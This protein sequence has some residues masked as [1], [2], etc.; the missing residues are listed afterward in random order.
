MK[1]QNSD[2]KART[3]TQASSEPLS[4]K[5]GDYTVALYKGD[6]TDKSALIAYT[7]N[8]DVVLNVASAIAA[9]LVAQKTARE[10]RKS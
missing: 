5:R 2:S 3:A 4:I 7:I 10:G 9:R 8:T 1:N 6:T